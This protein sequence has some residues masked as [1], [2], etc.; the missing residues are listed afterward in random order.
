[1]YVGNALRCPYGSRPDYEVLQYTKE[2]IQFLMYKNIKMIVIACNTETAFALEEL[3]K[4]LPIPI[5]GIIQPEAR[6]AFKITEN[7][8]IEVIRTEGTIR[9]NAY[10]EALQQIHSELEVA[11]LACPLFVP[12]VEKGIL[13]GEQAE[14][15]IEETLRP[16]KITT[17]IDTL[18]LGCTHYPL[19]ETT[20]KKV[21]S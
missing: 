14:Q 7:Q 12:M 9:S 6:T 17:N 3:K 11:S 8:K 2:M 21:R 13:Y 5:I 4:I 1:M 18:V 16:L 20:I 15:V 19:L 10:K